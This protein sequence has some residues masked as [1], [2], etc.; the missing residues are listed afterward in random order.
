LEI[1]WV[2][3]DALQLSPE[4]LASHIPP[5]PPLTT[6]S[7]SPLPR[8]RLALPVILFLLT[9]VSTFV[10]G[11]CRWA[12][13]QLLVFT[14]DPLPFRRSVLLFWREG[15]AYMF[16]M[17]LTLFFHEMGHFLA[18]LYYRIPASFPYFLPLPITPIGTMGAVI[19]MDNR[20][21]DRR[22]MFDIGIAGPLAG[23]VVAIPLLFYGAARLELSLPATGPYSVDLPTAIRWIV[24]Y[25]RPAGYEGVTSINVHQL[26]PWFMAGW[27][28]VLVTALNMMPVSQLDGGH[29][30]YTLFG[31]RAHWLARA[32][33]V[34]VIGWML[35][36]SQFQMMLMV[37]LILLIGVDHPPTA[38][39]RVPLGPVRFALGLASLS[40]PF[41]FLTTTPIIQR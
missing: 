25:T 18:T 20:D 17:L 15:L 16:W 31:R 1:R 3:D 19:R 29:V 13:D 32:F 10:A 2:N 28:G 26:N 37:V 9:C 35:Y 24:Q 14:S 27:V 40:I 30:T 23:L 41:L 22:Q 38:N 33:M 21:A 34:C 12:P 5:S 4:A 8:R 6:T 11:A 7:R 39:D 36:T